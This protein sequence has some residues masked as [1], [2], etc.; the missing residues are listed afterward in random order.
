M[1]KL[2]FILILS[3][4][5]GIFNVSAKDNR[6]G[7]RDR[8]RTEQRY[9][10]RP[11]NDRYDHNKKHNDDRKHHYNGH[12][13]HGDYRPG[14]HS[15]PTAPPPPP[16]LRPP[17]RP[18]INPALAYVIGT[19]HVLYN[20]IVMAGVNMPTFEVLDY[21]YA[22]DARCVYYNGERLPGA[23]PATFR[24]LGDGYARDAW[25]VYYFGGIV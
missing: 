22:R 1:K 3:L 15:R 4:S 14:G 25:N 21:G 5:L 23:D 11:G 18:H 19:A 10:R 17:R 16:A 13:H 20:G 12:N 7:G 9:D 2:M 8:N 6:K 24:I